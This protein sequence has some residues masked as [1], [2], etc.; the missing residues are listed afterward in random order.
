MANSNQGLQVAAWNVARGLS[1]PQRA[2]EI[3]QGIEA[4]DADVVILSESHDKERTEVDSDFASRLGYSSLTVAYQDTVPHSSDEQYLTAL[5]RNNNARMEPVRLGT[6]TG[7]TV[8]GATPDTPLS[9]IGA[10][11]DDRR[12]YFRRG[13]AQSAIDEH[14]PDVLLGDLNSMHGEDHKAQILHHPVVRGLS[15]AL[16]HARMRSLATRLVEMADGG[17]MRMLHEAGMADADPAH[18]PTMRMLGR[19]VVQLDHI[20]YREQDVFAQQF[21]VHR[22]NG[23]DHYAIAATVGRYAGGMMPRFEG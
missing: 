9:I 4:L 22:L 7:I 14:K 15:R 17:T 1:D 5:V 2:P 13:M 8:L 10:H 20:L 6:R 3:I 23:S 16:P 18:T 21:D 11:F 12:E 19:A